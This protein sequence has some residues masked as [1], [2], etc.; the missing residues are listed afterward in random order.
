MASLSFIC[1]LVKSLNSLHHL[2]HC[3]SMF[4]SNTNEAVQQRQPVKNEIILLFLCNKLWRAIQGPLLSIC[5]R[6]NWPLMP[7]PGVIRVCTVAQGTSAVSKI[8][9]VGYLSTLLPKGTNTQSGKSMSIRDKQ[10]VK[11][12]VRKS[13][14]V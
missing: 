3:S 8:K 13:S 12:Q 11:E 7:F 14:L 9:S 4:L 10:K 5:T 1:L 2:A 6:G